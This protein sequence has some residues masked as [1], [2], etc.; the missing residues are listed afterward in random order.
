MSETIT[1][2]QENTKV[3]NVSKSNSSFEDILAI[4]QNMPV[5]DRLKLIERLAATVQQELN[6]QETKPIPKK[7]L[8]GIWSHLP[9]ISEE[10]IDEARREA[11]ANF[12]RD[13]I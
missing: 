1:K 5:L 7:S 8:L 13:D 11:W 2:T 12:P 6:Q 3:E 9:P 4:V 10:D